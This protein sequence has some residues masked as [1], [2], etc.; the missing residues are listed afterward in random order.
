MQKAIVDKL[1]DFCELHGEKIAEHWYKA[2]STNPRTFAFR[3][4]PKDACLR[5]VMTIYTNMEHMFFAEDCYK[6]VEHVLDVGG[7]VEDFF[8]RGIPIEE[9]IY[10]L[11]LAR[12]HIWLYADAQ[13][14]FDLNMTDMYNYVNSTNRILLV[15]DYA[16]YI[17]TRKYRE[18]EA[19]LVK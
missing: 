10:A 13:A 17:T 12:R 5:H 9:V 4:L 2:L 6:A 15:F 19:R 14:L 18:M 8:A 16:T 1:M 7:F 3:K 11:I